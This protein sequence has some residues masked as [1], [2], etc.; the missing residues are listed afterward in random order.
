M[1]G[2]RFDSK[3]VSSVAP[4]PA[5]PTPTENQVA[6]SWPSKPNTHGPGINA[7]VA[8]MS[9][10]PWLPGAVLVLH[11]HAPTLIALT[12]SIGRKPVEGNLYGQQSDNRRP[13]RPLPRRSLPECRPPATLADPK[14]QRSWCES[15]PQLLRQRHQLE[16][17]SRWLPVEL[18]AVV[19]VMDQSLPV[20][21]G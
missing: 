2:S 4:S 18:P 8:P 21:L 5:M 9:R 12:R 16:E 14:S 13:T 11:G 1:A 19:A 10:T 15:S 20:E 6:K 3:R 17:L 7:I